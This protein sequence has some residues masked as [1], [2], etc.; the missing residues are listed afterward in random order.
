MT[1]EEYSAADIEV[2]EFDEHV[3]RTPVMYFDLPRDHP[4]LATRVLSRVLAHALHPA[5]RLAPDHTLR[6]VAEI[7]GDLAFTVTDDMPNALDDGT[8]RP[9]LGH[10]GALLGPERWTSAAA[11]ALGTRTVVEVWRDGHGVRQELAGLRPT[12]EPRSFEP[13]AGAGTRVAF[14]LDPAYFGPGTAITADLAGLDLHPPYCDEPPGPGGV[15]L[16][17]L[18]DGREVRYR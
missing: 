12:T 18:R 2:I 10:Y 17:D 1:G 15:T 7:H 6:V 9:R 16:R 13:L 5:T 14:A 3:R 4:D 11:A 8:G